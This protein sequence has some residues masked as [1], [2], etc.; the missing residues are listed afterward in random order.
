MFRV[1]QIDNYDQQDNL[2]E[3]GGCVLG[4]GVFD[5]VFRAIPVRY[6]LLH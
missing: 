6:L 3:F 1:N 5:E 2:Q 4:S